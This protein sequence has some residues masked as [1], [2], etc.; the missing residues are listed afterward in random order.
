MVDSRVYTEVVTGLICHSL[1]LWVQAANWQ[2]TN[3]CDCRRIWIKKC[4]NRYKTEEEL[5]G[6]LLL[7][8]REKVESVLHFVCGPAGRNGRCFK[9]ERWGEWLTLKPHWCTQGFTGDGPASQFH[10][11]AR[12]FKLL[13][14]FAPRAAKKVLEREREWVSCSRAA[15]LGPS[16]PRFRIALRVALCCFVLLGPTVKNHARPP[17]TS[18]CQA[19]SLFFSSSSSSLLFNPLFVVGPQVSN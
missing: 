4:T 13:I 5:I 14:Y 9:V 1:N 19:P 15:W 16:S 7:P 18:C 2:V 17:P 8:N 12:P 10:K 6:R 11:K 3:N